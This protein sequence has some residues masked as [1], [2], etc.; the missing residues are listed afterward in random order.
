LQP[1]RESGVNSDRY[2]QVSQAQAKPWRLLGLRFWVLTVFLVLLAGAALT[3]RFGGDLLIASDPLPKHSQ[4]AVVLAGSSNAEEARRAEALRLLEQ[5]VVDHVLLHVGKVW[6]WGQWLPDVVRRYIHGTYG[7][8]IAQQVFLCEM[9]T[10]VDGT[11]DEALGLRQ[12][13][14]QHGWRSVIV[15]SSNYHTRRV[16]LIWEAAL[17]GANPPFRFWLR[18]VPDGDF[19]ARGWWHKRR[20][21]KTWLL[22]TAKLV[23]A[24]LERVTGSV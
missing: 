4:V 12:C 11:A 19:E 23:W 9:L 15:V 3:L 2:S 14:E 6:S 21:A 22:E 24:C 1:S 10:T 7:N 13:L 18:G 16:R 17:A 8:G 20:Y 5:G